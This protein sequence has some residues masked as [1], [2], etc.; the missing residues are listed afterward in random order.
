MVAQPTGHMKSGSVETLLQPGVLQPASKWL[1]NTTWT[2]VIGGP[3]GGG[4]GLG[5]EW[6]LRKKETRSLK[7]AGVPSP[8]LSRHP[9]LGSGPK[10][11][12]LQPGTEE[13]LAQHSSAVLM[14]GIGDRRSSPWG[15][16]QQGDSQCGEARM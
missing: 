13:H 14:P 4:G 15:P 2:S 9:K 1:E 3:G 6:R 12:A 7:R 11:T 8:F 16:Q 10:D 5:G